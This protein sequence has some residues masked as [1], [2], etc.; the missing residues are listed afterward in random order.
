MCNECYEEGL[1]TVECTNCQPN[2]SLDLN[3]GKCYC[4]AGYYVSI[5]NPRSC[6]PCR[7]LCKQCI[8][9]NGAYKC[10]NCLPY[11]ELDVASESCTCKIGYKLDIHNTCSDCD[12]GYILISNSP[13]ICSAEIERCISYYE[14]SDEVWICGLCEEEDYEIYNGIC[15]PREFILNIIS[16]INT[17]ELTFSKYL[18]NE[19]EMNDLGYQNENT[20]LDTL[21]LEFN[22]LEEKKRY[23]ISYY[24]TVNIDTTISISLTISN[25]VLDRNNQKLNQSTYAIRVP[26]LFKYDSPIEDSEHSKP[27]DSINSDTYNSLS[28]S[29][30]YGVIAASFLGMAYGLIQNN[31]GSLWL[32][33]NTSEILSYIPLL[34]IEI[35]DRVKAVASGMSL[36]IFPNLIKSYYPEATKNTPKRYSEF[37]IESSEFISTTLV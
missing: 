31:L 2:S 3:S 8:E 16:T 21:D 1:G 29:V 10:I 19:I 30:S 28:T 7:E 32:W 14:S 5:I 18:I 35:P 11:A 24:S 34:N 33:L 37:G 27:Q 20:I 12:S 17:I 22:I 25:L 6:L 23:S 13:M 26:I 9:E 36:N 15:V 4:N